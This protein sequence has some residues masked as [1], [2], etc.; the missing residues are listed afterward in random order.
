MFRYSDISSLHPANPDFVRR[1]RHGNVLLIFLFYF[2]LLLVVIGYGFYRNYHSSD[3]LLIVLVTVVVSTL[4]LHAL[5]SI[6]K[7]LDMIM[8]VEF[9]N[10]LFTSAL[11]LRVE[12]TIIMQ[13]NG[14]VVYVDKGFREVFPEVR[15]I[16]DKVLD[17]LTTSMSMD[18]RTRDKFFQSL[19]NYD[20][21]QLVVEIPG[22]DGKPQKFML[23]L[24]PLPRPQGFFMIQARK[25]V[26]MRNA[27]DVA[28]PSSGA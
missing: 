1:K 7:S 5:Y 11:N 20:Y 21:E 8:A 28:I 25:Y 2:L 14:S 4:I 13:R 26:E 19:R 6:Q 22:A 24:C 15:A 9:Q 23:Y 27:R 10:A 12:F 18:D 3:V 17:F 16:D